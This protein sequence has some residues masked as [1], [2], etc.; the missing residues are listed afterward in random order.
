MF[1]IES[2]RSLPLSRHENPTEFTMIDTPW[3]SPDLLRLQVVWAHHNQLQPR[4]FIGPSAIS[5]ASL[6]LVLAGDCI[7]EG[8]GLPTAVSAG[9]WLWFPPC[10]QRH[11]CIGDIGMNWLSAGIAARIGERNFLEP[12]IPQFLNLEQEEAVRGECY[13]RQ[14][15]TSQS[16]GHLWESDGTARS[17]AG[18]LWRVAAPSL[19]NL[20]WPEWLHTAL[21]R[22]EREPEISV[23][24]L[25][26]AAHFSPAQ[27][28]RLW[29]QYL[30]Q[31]PQQ[32]LLATRLKRARAALEREHWP[33]EQI[34]IYSGFSTTQA[35]SRAFNA[36]M[37][38]APLAWRR[39]SRQGR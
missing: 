11:I 37:G 17:L 13:L 28:R 8:A 18:W 24:I 4:A 21:E 29:H 2:C 32:T 7:V 25:S 6:W 3:P 26:E 10:T 30:G 16:A 15:I 1:S 23:A 36:E 12:E 19:T 20:G 9:Q 22:I 34:A 33:L 39:T 38:M 35:L 31:S 5:V 27:F 14:L